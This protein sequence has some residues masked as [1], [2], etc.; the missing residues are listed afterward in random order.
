MFQSLNLPL[1]LSQ[2]IARQN[3]IKPYK[4]YLAFKFVH[5][6]Q[7]RKSDIDIQ[8]IGD[9][10]GFKDQR[11]VKAHLN[12]AIRLNWIGEDSQWLFIR[13]FDRLRKDHR[14]QGRSA[15]EISTNDIPRLLEL[16][17]GAKIVHRH[18]AKRYAQKIPSAEPTPEPYSNFYD[19]PKSYGTLKVSCS[20]IGDW[21]G[22]S[23]STATRLKQSAKQSGYLDYVHDHVN[24]G[25]YK[26]NF[27]DLGDHIDPTR[28][29]I[30]KGKI[31]IRLTDRFVISKDHHIYK[32]ATRCSV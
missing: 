3:L 4:V 31:C 22:F 9:I 26:S 2:D 16:L 7:V 17:L 29:F 13:S 15:I 30:K 19:E 12:T 28:L 32:F 8:Q 10:A 14:T 6:G 18:R 23:P 25:L 21:F 11:T 5:S 20:L 24:T 1:E 27:A